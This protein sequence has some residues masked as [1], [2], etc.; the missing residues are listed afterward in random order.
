MAA[1]HRSTSGW[2]IAR[3]VVIACIAHYRTFGYDVSATTLYTDRVTWIHN[4]GTSAPLQAEAI[5]RIG[6]SVEK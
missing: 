4:Y 5:T 3:L 6:T 2:L 1:T